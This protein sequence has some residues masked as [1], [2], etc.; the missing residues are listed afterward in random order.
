MLKVVV[1][2]W[3]SSPTIALWHGKGCLVTDESLAFRQATTSSSGV[4]FLLRCCCVIPSF[5]AGL[6][7]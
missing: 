1:W 3:L 5:P 4:V 6:F 7:K 2:R